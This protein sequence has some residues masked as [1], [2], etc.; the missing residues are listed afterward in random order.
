MRLFFASIFFLSFFFTTQAQNCGNVVE[1]QGTIVNH[2]NGTS[3]YTFYVTIQATSGGS[4]S[5]NLTIT[6]PGGSNFITN[7]CEPSLATTRIVQFG[8]YTRTTCS[9]TPMLDWTGHSNASC[10]GTTCAGFSM[11]F[12]P[13]PVELV[14]FESRKIE[15]GIS[16]KWQTASELNNDRFVIERSSEGREYFPI[17]EVMGKGTTNEAQNYAYIEKYP[18]AGHN[19]YRLKQVDFGGTFEY[20]PIQ[21]VLVEQEGEIRIYPTIP[22]NE[23]TVEFP[24]DLVEDAII[25]IYN[26]QGRLTFE[27]KLHGSHRQKV[28]L[29]QM[30]AGQYMVHVVNGNQ[31]FRTMIIKQ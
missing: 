22:S 27:H 7:V 19:Y 11:G 15:E 3:T 31:Y 26:M 8:P 28:V 14:S 29:P 20:S 18:D 21:S 17:G 24:E 13:L 12:S 23:L 10:G 5:V 9:G 30:P 16:L 2:G 25:S 4:K 6:C 1:F